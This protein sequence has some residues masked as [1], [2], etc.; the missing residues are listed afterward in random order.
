M[1]N[2][3]WMLDAKMMPYLK[4]TGGVSATY[5]LPKAQAPQTP[6]DL[7]GSRVWMV[8]R[9]AGGD[10]LF[11]SLYIDVVEQFED[12]LNVGD[13]FLTVN[14]SK[15][16]RCVK[17]YVSATSDFR[18]SETSDFS[19]GTWEAENSLFEKLTMQ[20]RRS[21]SVKLQKPP[22]AL[23]DKISDPPLKGSDTVRLEK[24]IAAITSRFSI[25]EVWSNGG[26]PRL[27]PFA[28]FAYHRLLS[29]RNESAMQAMGDLLGKAD[30]TVLDPLQSNSIRTIAK[31]RLSKPVVN[32]N[33]SPIDPESIYARKF[34]ARARQDIDLASG[35]EKTE[36]AEKKHQNMLRDLAIRLKD[37]GF[38]PM[39]S[40]SIDLFVETEKG[41]KTF[42]L[43]TAT[44]KNILVQ[45]AKGAF[46]LGCYK[47][48]LAY[49]GYNNNKLAL[50]IEK[51]HIDELDS[52]VSEILSSFE[53]ATFHYDL[54]KS[55]P[56]RIMGFDKFLISN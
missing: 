50:V 34:I 21:I 42:E 36:Y 18:T 26:K 19:K 51:T 6:S 24:M 16:Y 44:P 5:V 55:W 54:R 12:G 31:E 8:L 53:I 46:Q 43:K 35:V 14:P 28:N 37:I 22:R 41:C 25:E 45:S 33:L 49:Q 1:K 52:Y 40:S 47:A 48:A 11:A 27:P 20:V 3:I 2:F 9:G 39:Q 10:V 32:V 23:L 4:G 38:T 7:A 30:P 56:N 29:M 15:S 17:S 13:F